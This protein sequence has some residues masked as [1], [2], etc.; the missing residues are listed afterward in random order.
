MGGKK[1]D[2]TKLG[3]WKNV[4]YQICGFDEQPTWAD[5][6]KRIDENP[7]S[8]L[9]RIIFCIFF[10]SNL[11]KIAC[12]KTCKKIFIFKFKRKTIGGHLG[13]NFEI[14]VLF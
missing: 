14:I 4:G 8:C 13:G 6:Q 9:S 2:P 12:K 10:F 1:C 5:I 3:T 11:Y 7:V